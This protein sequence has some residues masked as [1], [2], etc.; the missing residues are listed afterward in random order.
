MIDYFI[1]EDGTISKGTYIGNHP[2]NFI[3]LKANGHKRIKNLK[4]IKECPDIQKE[5]YELFLQEVKSLESQIEIERQEVLDYFE[6]TWT[7]ANEW[8]KKKLIEK[9]LVVKPGYKEWQV[10]YLKNVMKAI[11][12]RQKVKR[13]SGGWVEPELIEKANQVPID[14]IMEF[15]RGDKAL[16][17]WHNEN[18]P[19]LSYHREGNFVKCFG[20]CGEAHSA[21]DVYQKLNNCDFVTAVKSLNN[22]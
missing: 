12:P 2:D 22:I 21:I 10:L 8:K 1:T 14:T 7:S 15:D 19:S 20:Q 3:E 16:C 9:T 17:L 18:T 4:I 11:M 13:T 6:K 5:I